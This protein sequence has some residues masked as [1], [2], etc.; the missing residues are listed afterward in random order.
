MKSEREIEKFVLIPMSF[1]L[2]E[3][4]F[5]YKPGKSDLKRTSPQKL[6]TENK[7]PG[8]HKYKRIRYVIG[9]KYFSL[10]MFETFI[11]R[12]DPFYKKR[13]R[14]LSKASSSC[15]LS[16]WYLSKKNHPFWK[17]RVL[18]TKWV[19]HFKLQF[20]RNKH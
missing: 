9:V 17:D 2:I 5:K 7:T 3:P 10:G 20:L 4:F 19:D 15:Q 14:I 13:Q 8:L 6:K 18:E 11:G 12:G 16:I 1:W